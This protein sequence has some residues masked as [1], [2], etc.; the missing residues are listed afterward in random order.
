M[1]SV[2]ESMQDDEFIFSAS[3]DADSE[4]YSSSSDESSSD[5][6][7]EDSDAWSRAVALLLSRESRGAKLD[8]PIAKL[9]PFLVC[10]LC[11]GYFREPS[12]IT[13]CGHTFCRSCL[14][15]FFAYGNTRCPTCS[16]PLG[17][18]PEKLTLCVLQGSRERHLPLAVVLTLH[19][20]RFLLAF[21]DGSD[22]RWN[23]A[24]ADA[25]AG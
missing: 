18:N 23:C 12:T 17:V 19:D 3:S 4:S 9:N 13:R 8:V 20:C 24:K 7:E 21:Q 5:S 16:V 25:T 14:F 1:A 10:E 15:K 22:Q 11:D 6:E 2:A